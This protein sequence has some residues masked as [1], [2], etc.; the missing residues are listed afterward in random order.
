MSVFPSVRAL[1]PEPPPLDERGVIE[2]LR[3]SCL[4]VH[5]RRGQGS[6]FLIDP[7]GFVI[8]NRHVVGPWPVAVLEFADRT[9]CLARVLR[10][11]RNLDLALLL[12]LSPPGNLPSLPVARRKPDYGER[13]L[14][15][16]NPLSLEGTLTQGIVSH[17]GREMRPGAFFVQTDT[18]VNHGN[19]GGPL[20]DKEGFVL[21]VTSF[22]LRD[23][24][25]LNFAV[26][27]VHLWQWMPILEVNPQR[28]QE[29]RYC[30]VCG[31]TNLDPGTWCLRCGATLREV[32][33]D[34][35]AEALKAAPSQGPAP[36][37]LQ[38]VDCPTCRHRVPPGAR[39]CRRCGS[40]VQG[41]P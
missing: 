34:K 21:G 19:S 5:V 33:F 1:S 11:S 16:G 29:S 25:N 35:I 36:A 23:A 2:R 38:V 27:A 4:A 13:V 28:L 30:P 31:F 10:S 20:V 40:S 37:P 15:F 6:G 26:S 32:S 18:S 41:A 24:T 12:A 7:R 17:P 3:A 39:F 22:G 14:A 8:T 9:R